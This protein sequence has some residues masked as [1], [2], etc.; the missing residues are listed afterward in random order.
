MKLDN[1]KAK[2]IVMRVVEYK[3]PTKLVAKQ[4]G[5]SQ[6]RVQQIV[7]EYGLTKNIPKLKKSGRYP[8][9]IYPVDLI[10]EIQKVWE[11]T[12]AGAP[13]VATYLRKKRGTS[14][15]NRLV[16]EILKEMGK[17]IESP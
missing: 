11:V 6:R 7:K 4:F 2:T 9:G 15:D 13:A 10:C 17:S 1:E 12:R 14:I 16:N 3:L 8:Y 5:V